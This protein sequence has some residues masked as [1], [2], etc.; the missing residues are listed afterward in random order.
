LPAVNMEDRQYKSGRCTATGTP[1]ML[2]GMSKPIR[3]RIR[4]GGMLATRLPLA[5]HFFSSVSAEVFVIK[6]FRQ[7]PTIF[8]IFSIPF[9]IRANCLVG[10]SFSSQQNWMK[11][12]SESILDKD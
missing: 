4:T 1:T 10:I 8:P 5:I 12:L 6:S 9:P 3:S 7:P 2:I 11:N